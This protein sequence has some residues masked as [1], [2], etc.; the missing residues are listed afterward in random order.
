MCCSVMMDVLILNIICKG[1]SCSCLPCFYTRWCHACMVGWPRMTNANRTPTPAKIPDPDV[2]FTR[3]RPLII[4]SIERVARC[5]VLTFLRADRA[6]LRSN[7]IPR[8]DMIRHQCGASDTCTACVCITRLGSLHFSLLLIFW[9]DWIARY[10]V[11]S[12]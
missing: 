5:L 7:K 10:L 9:N 8:S 12:H 2:L 1:L 11:T 3:E 4:L 6:H